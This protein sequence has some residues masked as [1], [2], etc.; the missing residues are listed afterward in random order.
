M[1]PEEAAQQLRSYADAL[2]ATMGKTPPLL[3]QAIDAISPVLSWVSAHPED[4]KGLAE[5]TMVAVPKLDIRSPSTIEELEAILNSE[6][7]APVTITADGRVVTASTPV[8]SDEA[9]GETT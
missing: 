3:V 1:N 4:A 2:R 6:D 9:Q 5:G 7:P 8:P